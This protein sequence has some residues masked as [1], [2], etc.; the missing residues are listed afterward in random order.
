M[1]EERA[2]VKSCNP[3]VCVS[4]WV[5]NR[6]R[7][8]LLDFFSLFLRVSLPHKAWREAARAGDG[9]KNKLKLY[10]FGR[11]RITIYR[12]P[13]V[14]YIRGWHLLALCQ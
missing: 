7:I 13:T 12:A 6:V 8:A 9:Q 10:P 5:V 4:V 3:S 14:A 2:N 1:V 11:R